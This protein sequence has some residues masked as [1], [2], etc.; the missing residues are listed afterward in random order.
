[1]PVPYKPIPKL[2]PELI[3]R[4]WSK[5]DRGEPNDCWLWK[6]GKVR[7]Y[8]CFHVQRQPYLA[9]RIALALTQSVPHVSLVLHSCDNP[10]CVNPN[11]L[12]V[13]T[14]LDNMDDCVRHGNRP[15]GAKCPQAKLTEAN[16]RA[17]RKNVNGYS[18]QKLAAI[19]GVANS[20]IFR[21]IHKV[22]WKSVED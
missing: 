14:Q 5:V 17:I 12:R 11:H 19:Y 16:V 6:A 18:Q 10:A 3:E 8:G 13:G 21:V 2:T 1:M 4:F 7:G 22:D 9:H 20:T 15:V